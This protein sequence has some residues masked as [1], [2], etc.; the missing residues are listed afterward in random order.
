[1]KNKRQP[2]RYHANK[3][4]YLYSDGIHETLIDLQNIYISKDYKIHWY[5][6]LPRY[7][8]YK[9]SKILKFTKYIYFK[10]S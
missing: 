4:G 10:L 6:C 9:I 1:M 7:E 8:R 2:Q 5:K 3:L